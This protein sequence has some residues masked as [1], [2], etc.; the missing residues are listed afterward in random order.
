MF[1][2]ITN[3]LIYQTKNIFQFFENLTKNEKYLLVYLIFMI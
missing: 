1:I 2:D 3:N